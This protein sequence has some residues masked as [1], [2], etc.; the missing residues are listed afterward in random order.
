MI[1]I[2]VNIFCTTIDLLLFENRIHKNY[3]LKFIYYQIYGSSYNPTTDTNIGIYGNIYN[4]SISTRKYKHRDTCILSGIII[5]MKL[6]IKRN[7]I[8]SRD[9]IFSW[10]YFLKLILRF[11]IKF[12]RMEKWKQK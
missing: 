5:Y 12:L 3:L 8:Y 2:H 10:N 11:F 7:K 1:I 9:E 6:G 4:V